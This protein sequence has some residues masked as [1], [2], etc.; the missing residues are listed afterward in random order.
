MNRFILL[1]L[2]LLRLVCFR[3][4][5][6]SILRLY[7]TVKESSKRS[8]V[9]TLTLHLRGLHIANVESGLQHRVL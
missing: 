6:H 8:D 5:F 7:V 9:R 3:L 4:S 1:F 2:L